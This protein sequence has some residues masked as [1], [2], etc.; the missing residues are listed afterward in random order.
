MIKPPA[1]WY[2]KTARKTVS[3]ILQP[4]SSLYAWGSKRRFE[5]TVP[6][7]ASL[8]V[9]CV[10]NITMGGVGKTPF[11]A[12][13]AEQL[14]A[15]ERKPVVLM[16]GYGGREKGPV[17]VAGDHTVKDVGDE[18]LLLVETAPV[19]V[20]RD[21]EAGAKFIAQHQLGDVI[22]MDDGFQNPS[23]VKDLS[24]ILIDGTAG[25]G[26]GQIFP[27]GPLR[28]LPGDAF[29]RAG[30]LVLVL[31]KEG[32]EPSPSVQSL[33]AGVKAKLPVFHA[34]LEPERPADPGPVVAFS[35]IG[36]PEK[37]FTS[38]KECGYTL[39]EEISYADHHQ[40]TP[41]DIRKLVGL[42]HQH[43]VPLLTTA[44][45]HVRLSADMK[46]KVGV[47]PVTMRVENKE[48]LAEL[49]LGAAGEGD[50]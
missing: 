21:R 10:G 25:L 3:D 26:N 16:R 23:L 17:L 45:D 48:Q 22:L 29:K 14:I 32:A 36:R 31:P 49:V 12:M 20:T 50:G 24:F 40:Y 5:K 39:V 18:A 30:A 34:W 28:E 4:F 43:G 2:D 9:I 8:P 46:K 27:A 37:F 42:S 11:A 6:Y 7:R 33:V 38:A 15:R 13:L 35:G 19:C 47:L 41:K 44:K 1:F